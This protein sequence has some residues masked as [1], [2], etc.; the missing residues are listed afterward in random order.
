MRIL[1]LINKKKSGKP[2]SSDE[3]SFIIDGF[4]TGIIPDYQISALLMAICFKG[5]NTEETAE[6]T[7]KMAHSGELVRLPSIEGIKVDKHSTGGVGDKTTLIISPIVA[8]CGVYV[9]KMSG[10]GL[11]HTG[12]T[13]DKL[14]AIPGLKTALSPEEFAETVKNVGVCIASASGNIAPA[15][16]KLYALRD[17]TGTVDSMPLIAASIMSKKIASPSDVVLLDVKTGKG[18]F[19]TSLDESVELAKIM[20]DIGEAAGKKTNALITNM[21]IPLGE[22]IGNTL[23]I[24]ESVEVLKGRGCGNL[25]AV[26]KLLAAHMLFLADKGSLEECMGLAEEAVSS[27][28]ALSKF[29]EMVEAQGGKLNPDNIDTLPKAEIICEIKAPH[30]GYIC[31]MDALSVGIAS[32]ILGAGRERE[33]SEIDYGAGIWIHK[34]YG[35]YVEEGEPLAT[36]YTNDSS[37][38]KD[39]KT[40]FIEAIKIDENEPPPAKLIYA[41]VSKDGVEYL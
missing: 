16:K 15:D 21:D 31:E 33:D 7:L 11:G 38:I 20:V 22:S 34:K 29:V 8:A 19:M 17:V 28:H 32:S 24:V 18:A 26:C 40:Q 30:K 27:G 41:F 14:E 13:I 23:E 12:G 10:R 2:L 6:L 4:I 39:A 1:D 3:I 9:A 36:F 37:K 25:T 5:M 35:D